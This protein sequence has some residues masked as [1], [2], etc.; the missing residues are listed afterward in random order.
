MANGVLQEAPA[1]MAHV[2]ALLLQSNIFGISRSRERGG[3]AVLEDIRGLFHEVPHG[4]TLLNYSG[5]LPLFSPVSFHRI[6]ANFAA[7]IGVP[8]AT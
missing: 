8:S 6:A 2:L 5:L 4:S 7:S 1:F 3:S